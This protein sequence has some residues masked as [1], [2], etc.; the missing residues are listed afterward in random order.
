MTLKYHWN[1][2]V[3]NVPDKYSHS[4]TPHTHQVTHDI[5]FEYDVVVRF[6]DI[7]DYLI[8]YS[9]KNKVD[10]DK[11]DDIEIAAANCYIRKTLLF[12]KDN[13]A[14]DLE[15]LEYDQDFK[16]FMHDRYESDAWEEFQESNEEY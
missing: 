2:V 11:L 8:P 16:E 9:L 6:G 15:E 7:V 5:D 13:D 3:L 4:D 10:K 14:L 1:D 12:L